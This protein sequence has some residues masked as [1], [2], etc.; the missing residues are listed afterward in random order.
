MY[1][2]NSYQVTRYLP[3]S[4]SSSDEA[5]AGP[6]PRPEPRRRKLRP[7]PVSSAERRA[8]QKSA[9][10][11]AALLEG[12]KDRLGRLAVSE[13]GLLSDEVGP[14]LLILC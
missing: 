2:L 14:M 6:L 13:G 3:T 9:Q 10:I 12:D 7:R 5:R 11:E 8:R 4:S 1:L